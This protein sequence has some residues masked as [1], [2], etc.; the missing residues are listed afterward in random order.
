MR[1]LLS[2]MDPDSGQE[3]ESIYNWNDLRE[4][5][6]DWPNRVAPTEITLKRISDED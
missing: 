1:V 4:W 2:Y 3:V 6:D 5:L